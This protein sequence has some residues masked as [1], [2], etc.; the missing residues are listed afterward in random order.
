MSIGLGGAGSELSV[1]PIKQRL[2][3]IER[4]LSAIE[5]ARERETE[6]ERWE[7]LKRDV[8]GTIGSLQKGF[9][10]KYKRKG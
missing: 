10:P 1:D 4:R 8:L 2:S 7:E 9:T 5:S 3:N 6:A